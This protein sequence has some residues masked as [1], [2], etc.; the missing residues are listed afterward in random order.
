M[1][2][3]KVSRDTWDG[4]VE[5]ILSTMG[6]S[7]GLGNVWRFPYLCFQN[8]GGKMKPV[9]IPQGRNLPLFVFPTL[10]DLRHRHYKFVGFIQNMVVFI[11]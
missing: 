10:S 3:K 6:Y 7:I 8:G 2:E 5:F 9:V 11:K 4:K 1:S